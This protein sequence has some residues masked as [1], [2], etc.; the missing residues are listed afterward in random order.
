MSLSRKIYSHR[1]IVEVFQG[2]VFLGKNGV[3]SLSGLKM[4][5]DSRNKS[6]ACW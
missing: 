3:F 6:M 5:K 4:R 2:K 1:L